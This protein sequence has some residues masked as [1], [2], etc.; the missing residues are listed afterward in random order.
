MVTQT[1]IEQGYRLHGEQFDFVADAEASYLL[2]IGGL[3]SGKT[4]A[5]AAKAMQFIGNHPGCQ[6]VIMGP[7]YEMIAESSLSV[8]QEIA[9][10]GF[11]TYGPKRESISGGVLMRTANGCTIYVRS[12]DDPWKLRGLKL[13][14]AWM[15]EP[16]QGEKEGKDVGRV[17]Q[18][19]A[20]R[21]R[22]IH[23]GRQQ[24]WLTSTPNVGS[25]LN[26]YWDQERLPSGHAIY[27]IATKEN[28]RN[29]PED[30]VDR[31]GQMFRG[32]LFDQEV[33]G[34]FVGP[35]NLVYAF[36]DEHK[37]WPPQSFKF[38]VAGVDFGWENNCAITVWG[39]DGDYR[40]W[41]LEEFYKSHSPIEEW[42]KA[43]QG[44][45]KRHEITKFFCDPSQPALIQLMRRAG[46]Q[47]VKHDP[48]QRGDKMARIAEVNTRL[49]KRGDGTYGLY[50][51]PTNMQNTI[52]E[53]K[54]YVGAPN[55]EHQPISEKP[56][57]YRDDAM[58]SMEYAICGGKDLRAPTGPIPMR[59]QRGR[60]SNERNFFQAGR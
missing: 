9:P 51:H 42:I 58:D 45:Q 6:G 41:G 34:L 38:V 60:Q 29:L 24:I 25:W 7:T 56:P 28:L 12:F 49:C 22:D 43:A 33:E 8:F 4:F 3:G 37:K 30:Y 17:F 21:M 15:D 48:R 32:A 39:F 57:K 47:A 1:G 53:F 44:L 55:P 59:W 10:D 14:W 27:R 31:L 11:L 19:L 46:L 52:Y 16:G 35:E 50:V 26:D 18:V 5:G 36:T 23:G 13:S 20:S 40:A 54:H 2:L